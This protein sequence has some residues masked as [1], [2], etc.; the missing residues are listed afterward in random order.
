MK[1]LSLRTILPLAVLLLSATVVYGQVSVLTQ[2][3]N[4]ERTGANLRETRLTPARV[5]SGRFGKL[6][7]YRVDGQVYG[8]PLVAAHVATDGGFHNVVYVTTVHNSVYAFDADQYQKRPYW[9][10]QFGPAPGVSDANFGCSDLNGQFGII[11]T[12]VISAARRTLYVV[13]LTITRDRFVQ[14]LHALNIRNGKERPGSPVTIRAY[15]FDPLQQNQRPALLLENGAVYIGYSSHCDSGRYHGYLFAYGAQSLRRIA[16]FDV[17]PT[18]NGG[19]IWMSGQGPAAGPRGHI[20]FSTSN[21]TYDGRYNFADS[22]LRLSV[23]HGLTMRDWFT[24]A[25]FKLINLADL[26]LDSSGVLRIPHTHLVTAEGKQGFMYLLNTRHLGHLGGAGV[27]QKLHATASELNGGPVYWEGAK[28]GPRIYVWGQD[29]VLRGYRLIGGKLQTRPFS[30]GTATSGYPGG[31]LSLS[32][33]GRHDGI[34]WASA[35]SRRAQFHKNGAHH[36]STLGVLRAYDAN[37]LRRE[38]WSSDRDFARDSCGNLSKNAPPTIAN[39]KV[40]LASFGSRQTGTGR[41]CV[42]GLRPKP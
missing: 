5:A 14:Q 38:L 10:D 13:S 19:S 15:G 26:D 30:R 37:D 7:S 20:Y 35:L 9:H 32:A 39:G 28:F 4:H 18:G 6:F 3:N 21:G 8:Q 34:I 24:P 1:I 42:Y 2:H 25:N 31:M 27:V 16:A 36:F 40:Y 29:D 12:P 11:G 22:V 23:R 41:L 17:T 33:Q